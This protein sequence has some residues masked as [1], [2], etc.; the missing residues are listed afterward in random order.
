MRTSAGTHCAGFVPE[1]PAPDL[2]TKLLAGT[3]AVAGNGKVARKFFFSTRHRSST[4]HPPTVPSQPPAPVCVRAS[5]T[6]PRG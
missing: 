3:A 6:N 5:L 2:R 1:A 4:P